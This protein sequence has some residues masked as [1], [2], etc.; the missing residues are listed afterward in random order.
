LRPPGWGTRTEN[1]R[2]EQ[3]IDTEGHGVELAHLQGG[4]SFP[5]GERWTVG[6]FLM[7]SVGKLEVFNHWSNEQYVQDTHDW[8]TIGMSGAFVP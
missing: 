3:L 1:G 6:P 5:I 2:T 4:I 8:L 7:F